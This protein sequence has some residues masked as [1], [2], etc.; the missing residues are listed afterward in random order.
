MNAH[1]PLGELTGK[2]VK[3]Q[4][5]KNAVQSMQEEQLE[6]EE[7]IYKKLAYPLNYLNKY[8]TELARLLNSLKEEI[9]IPEVCME[10][11][12]KLLKYLSN[13]IPDIAKLED[14]VEPVEL[15]NWLKE[16]IQVSARYK[17]FHEDVKGN[18]VNY[19]VEKLGDFKR[20]HDFALNLECIP[21]KGS[22]VKL[23]FFDF[24]N[25]TQKFTDKEAFLHDYNLVFNA[26]QEKCENGKDVKVT[27]K[28]ENKVNIGLRFSGNEKTG[29]IDLE[30]LNFGG[31]GEKDKFGLIK[32]EIAPTLVNAK[33]VEALA[34]FVLKRPS[35][36]LKI[37][38]IVK[39]EPVQHSVTQ[40][41]PKKSQ[42][43]KVNL[44]K[45]LKDIHKE[46]QKTNRVVKHT[47]Q[48]VKE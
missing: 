17:L 3:R 39:D 33:F 48:E 10:Q 13:E 38:K 42:F 45:V 5:V 30:I 32:L 41:I 2:D 8:M 7:K 36:L 21:E 37:A 31:M 6:E 11:P 9:E 18:F 4:A 44:M 15:L 34:A 20:R 28:V 47:Q 23:T 29:S 26:S 24:R 16:G 19:K 25:L 40:Y 35:K 27:L 12:E 1:N 43:K 46:T 14:E 22:D